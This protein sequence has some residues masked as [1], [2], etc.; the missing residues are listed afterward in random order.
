MCSVKP[1]L[2]LPREVFIWILKKLYGDLKQEFYK[3]TYLDFIYRFIVFFLTLLYLLLSVFLLM[4]IF[5]FSP[6]VQVRVI[7]GPENT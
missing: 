4:P 3:T 2:Y 1:K 5:H 7:S 6:V